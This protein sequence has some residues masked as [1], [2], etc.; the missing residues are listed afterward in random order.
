MAIIIVDDISPAC[1]NNERSQPLG[2]S[3]TD[4][5]SQRFPEMFM[6]GPTAV[7]STYITD[8]TAKQT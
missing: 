1:R 7:W 4:E 8:V 3:V 6:R 5:T 2:Y